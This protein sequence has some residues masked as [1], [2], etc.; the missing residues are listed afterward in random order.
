M[1]S[2]LTGE[3]AA[4]EVKKIIAIFIYNQWLLSLITACRFHFLK[5]WIFFGDDGGGDGGDDDDDGD[6]DDD[7]IITIIKFHNF[8][9][10]S[11]FWLDFTILTTFHI[12]N[13]FHNLNQISK[14]K[15]NFTISSKIPVVVSPE[16]M[17]SFRF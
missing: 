9:Q 16:A 8:D 2:K 11:Q 15:P 3:G 7:A 12:S 14:F 4:A 13:R 17:W 6:G 10:I 1:T 5:F